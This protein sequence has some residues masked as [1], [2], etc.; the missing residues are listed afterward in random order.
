V[1]SQ[2]VVIIQDD[3]ALI[4]PISFHA[5][6]VRRGEE[7]KGGGGNKNAIEIDKNEDREGEMTRRHGRTFLSMS[8]FGRGNQSKRDL[9]LNLQPRGKK[10]A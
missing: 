6:R 9:L 5:R 2:Q 10:I 3:C 1:K 4:Q 7:R 8:T